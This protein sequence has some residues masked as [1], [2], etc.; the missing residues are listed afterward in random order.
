MRTWKI[1]PLGLHL[2]GEDRIQGFDGASFS[3]ERSILPE[4]LSALWEARARAREAAREAPA[5]AI[6]IL[7]NSF[8]GV[9]G[10]PGCRFFD[11]RLAASITRRGHEVIRRTQAWIEGRGRRVIYGDTDSL[12]VLLGPGEEAA[13]AREGR[14]TAEAL[15]AWWRE[16][17]LAEHRLESHLE[18]RFDT[19]FLRFAMPTLRHTDKGTKKRYAGTVRTKDGATEV[20]IKG[21]EAVRTDW[22]A[23]ARE[24]QRELLRRVFAGEPWEAWLLGVRRDVLA[25]RL[26]D[27]LVYT[28]RLRRSLDDYA[29][30]G[31]GAPSHVRAARLLREASPTAS[32]REIAYVMTRRGP[33]PVDRRTAPLDYDH[34]VE[35][36]LAAAADSI[37]PL[38]DTSFERVAGRQLELF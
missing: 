20:V 34:Y 27:K 14:E 3:R 26:D 10:T 6:K 19:H 38:L 2:P 18:I 4:L 35:K 37:L 7:M 22:T 1:D 17:V 5:R 21:L 11:P 33:E 12:F 36:Q 29:A 23:L 25:G 8:Y 13:A 24:A 15:N 31:G 32:A 16:T 30:A 9:L 28:K